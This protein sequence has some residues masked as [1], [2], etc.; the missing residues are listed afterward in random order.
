MRRLAVYSLWRRE[1]VRFFR[2]RSRVAGALG[3]PLLL[4][5]VLGGG[6]NASFRPAGFAPLGY[7]AYF[8]PG[9][10]VLVVLF[11]AIFA[12]I[13]VVEDRQTGFLQG[14]LVAPVP[15]WAILLGQVAGATTLGVLQALLCL[16]LAPLAGIDLSAVRVLSATLVLSLLGFGL[17]SLGLVI[18]WRMDTTQGFHAIMNLLLIPLWLLSGAFFPSEGAPAPLAWLVSLNPLTYGVAA[19]RHA[20]YAGSS[21]PL[22]LPPLSLSL[23][24]TCAASLLAFAAAVRSAAAAYTGGSGARATR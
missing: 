23:V 7:L 3:Q 10:V 13:A 17:S 14:V 19:F 21:L 18:A 12:T 11:T 16:P 4:W 15:G 9:M 1:L 8:F 5:F 2:Q 22:P 24:V 20:L 6:M